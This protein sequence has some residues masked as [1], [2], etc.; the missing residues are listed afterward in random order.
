MQSQIGSLELDVHLRSLALQCP[1]GWEVALVDDRGVCLSGSHAGTPSDSGESLLDRIVSSGLEAR[2]VGHREMTHDAK[3]YAYY[4]LPIVNADEYYG[5]IV[6]T[7]QAGGPTLPNLA[8]LH[9][10][11]Q[12]LATECA[13]SSELDTMATELADRYEELNLVYSTSDKIEARYDDEQVLSEVVQNVVDYLQS[14]F[15]ILSIPDKKIWISAATT[16]VDMAVIE[17]LLKVVQPKI[18]DWFLEHQQPL[19]VNNLDEVVGYRPPEALA[20]RLLATPVRD[21]DNR[22][23]GGFAMCKSLEDPRISNSD[24]NL[25]GAMAHRVSKVIQYAYDNVT[26]LPTQ[27][28]FMSQFERSVDSSEPGTTHSVL[29]V[30]ND[31]AQFI[32]DQYGAKI[33]TKV[34][35]IIASKLRALGRDSDLCGRLDEGDLVLALIGCAPDVAERKANEFAAQL[36]ENPLVF[37][38]N[39]VRMSVSVGVATARLREGVTASQAITHARL[40]NHVAREDIERGV[41]QFSSDSDLVARQQASAATL[42]CIHT[43]LV[44]G[45]F[46]LYAQAIAPLSSKKTDPHFEFLLRLFDNDGKMISPADFIPIAE[47]HNLMTQIDLWVITNA[48]RVMRESGLCTCYPDAIGSINL[49]GQSLSGDRFL[50]QVFE[51]V[52]TS[53]VDPHNICF[54]VTETAAIHDLSRA[55]AFIAKMRKLGCRFALD[56]FGAG[57]SSFTYLRSLDLDYVKIDGSF[58]KD[59]MCDAVAEKMVQSIH[60]VG[61]AMGLETV[62]EYVED[63]TIAARLKSLGIHFGQGFGIGKPIPID[64]FLAQHLDKDHQ[65]HG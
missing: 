33:A 57:L 38:I 44:D 17:P 4:V 56:D 47:N 54:E 11:V 12:M 43:A 65:A 40:A 62:A 31:E 19:V 45:G 58:V 63:G 15:A 3:R 8:A 6:L 1:T 10:V 20:F 51:L 39:R 52:E 23:I 14:K 48:L 35:T 18:M 60:E 28:K 13:L 22:I 21:A 64:T 26:G 50:S 9:L 32:L 34:A 42:A 7:A 2:E 36:F 59:I 27:N 55:Q 49:S 46:E 53:A 41:A 30:S 5:A 37:G 16:S 25:V 24:K 61:T 29:Y